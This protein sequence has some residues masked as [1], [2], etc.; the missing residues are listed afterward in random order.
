MPGLTAVVVPNLAHRAHRNSAGS[1]RLAP[2][3]KYP[4]K[5]IA[6]QRRNETENLTKGAM[7]VCFLLRCDT[8]RKSPDLR[9]L[10]F[11]ETLSQ[12]VRLFVFSH[13]LCRVGNAH[14]LHAPYHFLFLFRKIELP[15]LANRS[16][17]LSPALVL[18]NDQTRDVV[19][20][21]LG[22]CVLVA[23][24]STCVVVVP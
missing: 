2:A 16:G 19:E 13:Q 4:R 18:S 12:S 21:L 8:G 17:C 14:H 23:V 1:A 10:A 22:V 20:D 11:D 9:P 7:T 24:G 5:A 3:N 15:H 6:A